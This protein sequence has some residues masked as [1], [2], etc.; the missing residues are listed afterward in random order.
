MIILE[1]FL[2]RMGFRNAS[3]LLNRHLRSAEP[4]GTLADQAGEWDNAIEGAN[5]LLEQDD[6]WESAYQML[7][8][9]YAQQGNRTQ[10][11]RT[12]NRC[13]ETLH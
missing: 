11:V 8:T 3:A 6:C 9:A 1:E 2:R 13:R 4:F 10:V 7:M 5:D 12:L